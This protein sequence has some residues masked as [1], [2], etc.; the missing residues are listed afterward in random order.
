MPPAL[1][2]KCHFVETGLESIR[3]RR[4]YKVSD[5]S[6]FSASLPGGFVCLLVLFSR[7]K[8]HETIWESDMLAGGNSAPELRLWELWMVKMPPP[9]PHITQPLCVKRWQ[10]HLGG[11]VIC[12][13]TAL[14]HFTSH[15]ELL[16]ACHSVPGLS[17]TVRQ[18]M[19][20]YNE[21]CS[22]KHLFVLLICHF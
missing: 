6:I 5:T 4:N 9:P 19:L 21:L 7:S 1:I 11:T 8:E 22:A 14:P 2:R 17:L 12:L 13:L 15:T 18:R 10:C 3:H 20:R 16:P